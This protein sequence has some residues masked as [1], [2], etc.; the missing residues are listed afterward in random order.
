VKAITMPDLVLLGGPPGVGKTSSIQKLTR[1]GV[2]CIEADD[3]SPPQS[4][5]P[6]DVAIQSVVEAT[7]RKFESHQRVVLSW[8]FAKGALYQP[9]REHF[10]HFNVQQIYLVCSADELRSR[11]NRR[12]DEELIQYALGRLEL[13]HRLPFEK[14]DTTGMDPSQVATAILGRIDKET[15]G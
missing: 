6:R 4:N 12:R 10:L 13:I 8:V 14:I 5:T 7:Q 2:E 11:L 1:L 9:F 15:C 3:L